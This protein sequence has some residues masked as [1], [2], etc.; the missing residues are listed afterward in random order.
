MLDRSSEKTNSSSFI[1]GADLNDVLDGVMSW[2]GEKLTEADK[3]A[4]R[5][6][7]AGRKSK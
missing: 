2:N 3:E 5:K 6:F 4:V 1:S 7:L